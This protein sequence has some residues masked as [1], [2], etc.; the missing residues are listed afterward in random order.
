VS[1]YT[2][3]DDRP[4]SERLRL[5][6]E[7]YEPVSRRFLATHAPQS[8]DLALDLGCGPG[9]STQLL[10]DVCNPMALIGI[11]SSP[12]FLQAAR[13]RLPHVR[14]KTHDVTTNPLPG[15]PAELI[16]ARLLL[17]HVPDPVAVAKGWLSQLRPGGCL[18]IE[19][20]EGVIDP[21]GPLQRYEEVSRQI[22]RS[23][24]GTMDAGALLADLGG[25]TRPVTVPGALAAEI[26]LSNVR[27]WRSDPSVP[28][29]ED[30][31]RELEVGL[32]G[33]M[34]DDRGATV[35]WLVRQLSIQR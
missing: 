17:A 28:G 34:D 7:A 25:E 30:L 27:R 10:I 16:Y 14:F 6:A 19:D 4:A 21:P 5:V 23:G 33:V 20:L 9:F 12:E 31:L 18:L 35:S 11:D 22:V 24:G 1:R 2:F 32:V 29:G 13:Q 3:G 15:A 8:V 26:Y